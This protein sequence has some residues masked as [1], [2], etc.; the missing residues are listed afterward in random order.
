VGR[1]YEIMTGNLPLSLKRKVFNHCILP[2][3]TYSAETWR[4]AKKLE[5]KLRSTQRA[6][7]RKMIGVTLRD[8]KRAEWIREQTGVADIILSIK[9]KK[10]T[11]AGH[12][13]RRKDNRWTVRA[14]EWIPRE[15][16]RNR[17]RQKVRWSDEIKKFAGIK[18]NQLAQDRVDWRSLG[19]AFVLQWT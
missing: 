6:M 3:L 16:K 2:V 7:E 10:W 15:G 19:E 17:G 12:V 14:T 11:W 1:H 4:I 9:R 18:W 8:K 5:M 13:M